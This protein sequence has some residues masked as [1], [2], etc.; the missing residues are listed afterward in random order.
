MNS[1]KLNKMLVSEF[2][3]L[4]DL[5]K[6]E[7]EWQEGDNTGSHIVY[8]DVLTPYLRSCIKN[9]NI[10]EIKKISNF[11]ENLLSIN[12]IYSNEVITFSVLES[13]LDLICLDNDIITFFG[14]NSKKIIFELKDYHENNK[15]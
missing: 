5:Y 3:N 13:I 15:L 11:L 12:D 1:F 8:G 2:P 9:K 10:N 6:K 4:K 7:V 14:K